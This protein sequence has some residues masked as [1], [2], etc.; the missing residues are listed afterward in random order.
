MCA[1]SWFY[2]YSLLWLSEQTLFPFGFYDL[3]GVGVYRDPTKRYCVESML[4]ALFVV[5][6]PG[7]K[8]Y[9]HSCLE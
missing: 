7:M 6:Y 9:G 4:I 2:S 8:G 3:K 5:N 1:V